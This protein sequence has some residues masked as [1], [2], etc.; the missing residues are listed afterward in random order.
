[1]LTGALPYDAETPI[2]LALKHVN[3]TPRPPKEIN[4]NV[5]EGLSIVTKKLFA[6]HPEDRYVSA[7]ELIQDLQRV[8]AGLPPL[9]TLPTDMHETTVLS[10]PPCG[11]PALPPSLHRKS[12]RKVA[13]LAAA[14]L[15]S[16]G[17]LSGGALA[18]SGDLPVLEQIKKATELGE[19][20]SEVENLAINP[21]A[22]DPVEEEP[23][24]KD[25]ETGGQ[26]QESPATGGEVTASSTPPATQ[27]YAQSTPAAPPM[28]TLP[29]PVPVAATEPVALSPPALEAPQAPLTS[30]PAPEPPKKEPQQVL[31]KAQEA[32]KQAAPRTPPDTSS[33][34]RERRSDEDKDFGAGDKEPGLVNFGPKGPVNFGPVVLSRATSLK[35]RRKTSWLCNRTRKSPSSSQIPSPRISAPQYIAR[36]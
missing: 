7:S 16:V 27:S 34:A 36:G 23:A 6:T 30:S 8:H 21:V 31:A 15:A 19:E 20:N 2:G 1:M 11:A 9:A 33:P 4:S 5:P 32:P 10:R 25:P 13:G 18:L 35:S 14:A 26:T 17:L 29:A 28:Q 22:E 3:E 24:A 12:R